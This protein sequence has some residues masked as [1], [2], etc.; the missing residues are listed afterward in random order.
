[1][2][3]TLAAITAV[4]F[5]ANASLVSAAEGPTTPVAGYCVWSPD[6][7]LTE[8]SVV[9]DDADCTSRNA[10]TIDPRIEVTVRKSPV[11]EGPRDFGQPSGVV[12]ETEVAILIDPLSSERPSRLTFFWEQYDSF[13]GAVHSYNEAV[14]RVAEPIGEVH[15]AYMDAVVFHGGPKWVKNL[16]AALARTTVNVAGGMLALGPN[17]VLLPEAIIRAPESILAGGSKIQKG[18]S[19]GHYDYAAKGVAEVCGGVGVLASLAVPIAGRIGGRPPLSI[20]PTQRATT[21]ANI[22]VASGA[23]KAQTSHPLDLTPTHGLTMKKADFRS[24]KA[25]VKAN[26][27]VEPI[28]Y[29]EHNGVR[30]VVDGHHRLEAAIQTGTRRVPIERVELPYRSYKTVADLEYSP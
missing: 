14:D 16:D 26:G 4:A 22:A 11:H 18:V 8:L 23:V 1:M 7:V 9:L 19:E 3:S 13:K 25:S 30:Y 24:L 12:V 5:L 10:L 20:R 2:R 6:P 21:P 28:R 27:V 15:A 29:V 17:L